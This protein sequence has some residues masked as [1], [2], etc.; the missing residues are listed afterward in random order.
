[1]STDNQVAG[2]A[3]DALQGARKLPAEEA[4][5]QLR[6]FLGSISSPLPNSARLAD[7]SVALTK[8]I[9]MLEAKGS[10]SNDDWL[11]AIQTMQS[12]ANETS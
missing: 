8:L 11:H 12:L 5:T 6:E 7:A 2:A 1:M 10:A 3:L 4:V 9:Q